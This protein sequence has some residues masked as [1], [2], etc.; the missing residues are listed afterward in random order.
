MA[1]AKFKKLDPK[2]KLPTYNNEKDAGMDLYA[3]EDYTV[4]P[5]V[6][7]KVRTGLALQMPEGYEGQVRPR[8]GNAFKFG[9]SVINSPG[10]IDSGFRGE[11]CVLLVKHSFN[12][13]NL[14]RFLH[15]EKHEGKAGDKVAQLVIKAIE[16][17]DIVEIEEFDAPETDRGAKGFGSSGV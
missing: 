1:T 12:T 3:L 7:T 9:L 2:A 15:L 13:K 17:H 6:V 4:T 10:T 16:Y 11:I 5:G 8:S 14:E